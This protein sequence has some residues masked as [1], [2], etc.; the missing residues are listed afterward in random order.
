[1]IA[2]LFDRQR[3]PFPILTVT[4]AVLCLLVSVPTMLDADLYRF[5]GGYKPLSSPWQRLT[6]A[7]QHGYRGYSY[8]SEVVDLHA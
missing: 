5:L 2:D 4:F 1:M 8:R 6:L 7:F 3:Q